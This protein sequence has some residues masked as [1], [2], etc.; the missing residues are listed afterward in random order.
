MHDQVRWD[1][2]RVFLAIY[3]EH[4]LGQAAHRLAI[5]ASTVSRRLDSLEEALGMTLFD[6][7]RDGAAPTAAAEELLSIAERMEQAAVDL[8]VAAE[9]FEVEP[10]GVVRITAPPGIAE[11][12]V[13]PSIPRLIARYPRLRVELDSTISYVDLTRRQA[14][15]AIRT[16]RPTAGDLVAKK[17]TTSRTVIAASYGYADSLGVLRDPTDAQWITWGHD[18]NHIPSGRWVGAV[19]PEDSIVL[20]TSSFTAQLQALRSGIGV[21][22]LPKAF[23]ELVDLREVRVGRK[24]ARNLPDLPMDQVWLVGHRALRDVPRVAAVWQ[25]ILDEFAGLPS[26]ASGTP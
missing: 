21:A 17:L 10:E 13:A 3:R 18:L 12:L 6:R 4:S 7:T 23:L 14:D 22:L 5:N 8:G 19:V 1:D 15:L 9:A 16:M 25:F 24:L 11:H 20:R 26:R 2:L